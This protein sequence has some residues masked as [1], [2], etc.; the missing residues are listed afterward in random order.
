MAG[1]RVSY[2]DIQAGLA[3]VEGIGWSKVKHGYGE[4]YYADWLRMAPSS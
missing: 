4:E 2:E 3:A 1:D